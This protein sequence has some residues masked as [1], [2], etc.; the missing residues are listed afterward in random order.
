MFRKNVYIVLNTQNFHFKC[1]KNMI[2]VYILLKKYCSMQSKSC[3]NY[4][5][6]NTLQNLTDL[7]FPILFINSFII[8]KY[9]YSSS[10]LK[11]RIYL[12]PNFI[13]TD[14]SKLHSKH[15]MPSSSSISI[16]KTYYTCI[17][18]TVTKQ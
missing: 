12:A 10:V 8:L 11:Y 13:I 9:F 4:M 1:Y 15:Q 3:V 7:Q 17:F 6:C 18:N 5:C 16:D 2:I 14:K